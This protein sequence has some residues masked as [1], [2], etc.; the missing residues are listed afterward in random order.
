MLSD[1]ER[2]ELALI[3][4]GLAAADRRFADSFRTGSRTDQRR[5][6]IRALLGFGVFVLV[7][8]VVTGADGLFLQGLVFVGGGI[9]WSRWR[10]G[11]ARRADEAAAPRPRGG[12]RPDGTPPGGS[13]AV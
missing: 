5:W 12:A 13:R 1:R 6:P 2:H 10:A 11:R 9:A 4:Q 7:V 8:A 3:E